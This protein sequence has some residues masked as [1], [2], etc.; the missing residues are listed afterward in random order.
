MYVMIPVNYVYYDSIVDG[1]LY[2]YLFLLGTYSVKSGPIRASSFSFVH[3][4][5]NLCLNKCGIIY[6][7]F[8]AVFV[9]CVQSVVSGPK[10][11]GRKGN[12]L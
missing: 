9:L 2:L 11:G 8:H 1:I 10:C 3:F 6:Y 7:I 12:L 4:I 5:I